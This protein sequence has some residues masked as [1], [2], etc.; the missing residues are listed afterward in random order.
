MSRSLS[1]AAAILRL[2]AAIDVAGSQAAYAGAHELSEAYLSDI[3]RGK[4][5]LT[6][7]VAATIGLRPI[8][9]YV[10]TEGK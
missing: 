10:H 1:E 6:A 8:T 4:R 9:V 5:N 2:K 7:R 3:L